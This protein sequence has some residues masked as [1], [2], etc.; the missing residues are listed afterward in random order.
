MTGGQSEV[1]G[2]H[3]FARFCICHLPS[4]DSHHRAD[5]IRQAT[6]SHLVDPIC[7]YTPM[8]SAVKT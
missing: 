7:D 2:R 4:R 1:N 3:R 6:I 5:S 8:A